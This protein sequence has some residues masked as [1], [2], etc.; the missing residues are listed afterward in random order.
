MKRKI[1]MRMRVSSDDGACDGPALYLVGSDD[2]GNSYWCELDLFGDTPLEDE[3][4]DVFVLQAIHL[5]L[6]AAR[7]MVLKAMGE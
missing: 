3:A 5:K 1:S 2:L 6:K 7:L 4:N